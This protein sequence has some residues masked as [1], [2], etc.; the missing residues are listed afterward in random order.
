MTAESSESAA[1]ATFTSIETST[2]EDWQ[3][4]AREFGGFARLLPDRILKHLT[5]LDGDFGVES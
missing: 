4:I 2:A 1:R 5:L 3:L